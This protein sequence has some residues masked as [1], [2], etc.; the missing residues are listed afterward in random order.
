[1]AVSP[2]VLDDFA[3][4][5]GMT[6]S[7]AEDLIRRLRELNSASD[8]TSSA[9]DTARDAANRMASSQNQT[10][11][12]IKNFG[13]NTSSVGQQL[14]GLPSQIAAANGQVF[15]SVIPALTLA[16]TDQVKS[17]VESSLTGAGMLAGSLFGPMGRVFGGVAGKIAGKLTTFT[18]DKFVAL[19]KFFL[20]GAEDI[21]QSYFKLSE[22]GATFAGSLTRLNEISRDTG[23]S[24]QFMS[25]LASK[26]ASDLAMLGGTIEGSM[27]TF[28]QSV[29]KLDNQLVTVYGGFENLS[30]EALSYLTLRRLQGLDDSTRNKNVNQEMSNYLYNLKMLST[31]TGKTSKQ[32]TEDLAQRT[33]SAAAQQMIAEMSQTQRTNFQNQLSLI[34]DEGTKRAYQD[35]IMAR[36]FGNAVSETTQ[37]LLTFIPGLENQFASMADSMQMQTTTSNEISAQAIKNMQG[38]TAATRKETGFLLQG[39]ESGR[40]KAPILGDLQN[41]LTS[42]G[43]AA[44][45]ANAL[46]DTLKIASDSITLLKSNV[47]EVKTLTDTVGNILRYQQ[48]IQNQM[49]RF[50]MGPAFADGKR[51]EGGRFSAM[52][53]FNVFIQDMVLGIA[54]FA[55]ETVA[56]ILELKDVMGNPMGR[57]TEEVKKATNA[58]MDPTQYYIDEYTKRSKSLEQQVSILKEQ[59]DLAANSLLLT[60]PGER[61]EA[62]RLGDEL[63]NAEDRLRES[64]KKLKEYEDKKIE[65]ELK[66]QKDMEKNPGS[67]EPAASFGLPI[68]T[69]A[70]SPLDINLKP[71]ETTVAT[72]MDKQNAT[73]DLLRNAMSDQGDAL[74]RVIRDMG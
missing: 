52:G 21:T 61:S 8:G 49:N 32:I 73:I 43:Q 13:K 20:T 36:H 2:D 16:A 28:L 31:V 68:R 3:R 17:M 62:D 25:N 1:M 30:Q 45:Y 51:I 54:K 10:A 50:F 59:R 26:S 34:V 46:P 67:T 65:E 71:F 22:A 12:T 41:Y 44:T 38:I 69:L 7:A 5:M 37:R 53:A 11:E 33:K 6:S 23:F 64:R 24:L 55:D 42:V 39:V 70:G 29:G 72:L 4:R 60:P 14:L 35:Y 63:K 9:F 40:F 19:S 48:T 58:V 15:T 18:I 47:E 66:R 56:D 57:I 27:K 74:R